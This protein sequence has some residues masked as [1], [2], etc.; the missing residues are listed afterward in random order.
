MKRKESFSSATQRIR[1]AML[2][3]VA[4]DVRIERQAWRVTDDDSDEL[5]MVCLDS[6][7]WWVAQRA[8][9]RLTVWAHTDDEQASIAFDAVL[10]KHPGWRE[11]T[12]APDD[13]L[14]A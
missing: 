10:D 11:A 4:P 5:V 8:S 6:G 9:D 7:S 1:R 12:P 13:A 3:V 14:S 2:G